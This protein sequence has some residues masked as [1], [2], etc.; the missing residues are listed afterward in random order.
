MGQ[1]L[2]SKTHRGS[3]I[4]CPFCNTRFTT[5]SGLSHHLE[6]GACPRAPSL[7]RETIYRMVRARDPGGLITRKTIGWKDEENATYQASSQ[8]W[9]GSRYECYLCHRGF[10]QL[11]GLNQHLESSVHKQ[12]VYRCP[13]RQ[14]FKNFATL[15][16]LFNHLESESCHFIR[17]ERVQRSVE[18]V[19]NSGRVIAF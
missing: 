2:N 15:A 11:S 1:H 18:A 14:C 16:G 3:S 5:A 12:Q 10:K 4:T 7:N 13:N 19:F 9:N 6:R 8:T 17:F